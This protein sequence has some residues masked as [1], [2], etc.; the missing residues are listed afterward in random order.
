[1]PS[2][3]QRIAS[4]LRLKLEPRG[5]LAPSPDDLPSRNWVGDRDHCGKDDLVDDLVASVVGP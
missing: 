3:T 5:V 4:L 1:M 2:P